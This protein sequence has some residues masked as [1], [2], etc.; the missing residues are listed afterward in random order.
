M[1]ESTEEWLD[2]IPE[3]IVLIGGPANGKVVQ[4]QRDV[5]YFQV[6]DLSK[7]DFTK[8]LEEGPTDQVATIY[9]YKR[10]RQRSG[11]CWEFDHQP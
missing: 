10:A 11:G 6:S 4:C 5:N 9:T 7:V 3:T 8:P 2:D 1:H